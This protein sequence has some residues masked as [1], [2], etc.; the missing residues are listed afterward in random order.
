MFPNNYK[1]TD[2]TMNLVPQN[3]PVLPDA[4][5]MPMSYSSFDDDLAHEYDY[6]SEDL[7]F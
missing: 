2:L 1:S 3:K 7:D 6:E 5:A 4:T